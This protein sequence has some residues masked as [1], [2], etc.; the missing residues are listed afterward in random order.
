MRRDR[1]C[2]S[3]VSPPRLG[4]SDPRCPRGSSCLSKSR[5]TMLRSQAGTKGKVSPGA[6]GP[7]ATAKAH[8]LVFS[9]LSS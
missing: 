7:A 6:R 5:G 1:G 8:A 9:A 3:S 4:V 2:S